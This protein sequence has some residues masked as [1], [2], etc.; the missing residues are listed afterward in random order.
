MKDDMVTHT[1]KLDDRADGFV[2]YDMDKDTQHIN[3]VARL[4]DNEKR[5][6][7]LGSGTGLGKNEALANALNVIQEQLEYYL[8]KIDEL[9]ETAYI[10]LYDRKTELLSPEGLI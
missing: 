9:Y 5:I 10:D 6:S 7:L 4:W 2:C 3:C 1:F 8:D